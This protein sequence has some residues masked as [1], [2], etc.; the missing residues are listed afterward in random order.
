MAYVKPEVLAQNA[1][2]GS[3]AAGCPSQCAQTRS[4]PTCKSCQTAQ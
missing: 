4:N 3:F 1:A 2:E